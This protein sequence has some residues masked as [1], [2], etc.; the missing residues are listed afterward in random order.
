MIYDTSE[1]QAAG[2]ALKEALRR[3][4]EASDR[5]R[6]LDEMR[7][8][9]LQAVSHELRTPLTSILGFALPRTG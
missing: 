9:F 8:P 6:S 5:L 2:E 4:Q 7:N 3:E 1:L